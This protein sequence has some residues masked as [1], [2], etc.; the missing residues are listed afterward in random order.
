MPSNAEGSAIKLTG[1]MPSKSCVV[2]MLRCK[3][4]S[5]Y[6]GWTYDIDRRLRE[7][8]RGVASKYTR[9]RLPLALVYLETMASKN[10]AMK[11]EAAIKKMSKAE[12]EML[13]ARYRAL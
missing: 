6:T 13:T 7:H 2:Y 9:A 4:N 11:R 12:K 3:D 5:L 10:E 8:G 1:A